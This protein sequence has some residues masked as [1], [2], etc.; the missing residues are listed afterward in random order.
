ML[1][2]VIVGLSLIKQRGIK[3]GNHYVVSNIEYIIFEYQNEQAKEF[4]YSN[5]MLTQSDY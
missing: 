5:T 4:F 3:D 1:F 2:Q